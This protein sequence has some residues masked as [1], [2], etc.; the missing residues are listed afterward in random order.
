MIQFFKF[1]QFT[2]VFVKLKGENVYRRNQ[3]K[4]MQE[5]VGPRNLRRAKKVFVFV[6]RKPGK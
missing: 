4:V 5:Y 1:Y 6:E 3:V 2:G